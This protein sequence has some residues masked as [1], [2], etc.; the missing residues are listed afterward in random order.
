MFLSARSSRYEKNRRTGKRGEIREVNKKKHARMPRDD[1]IWT[2]KREWGSVGCVGSSTAHA[3]SQISEQRD[4]WITLVFTI[5][6]KK[7]GSKHKQRKFYLIS[8]R[9]Y[10]DSGGADFPAPDEWGEPFLPQVCTR[11]HHLSG[12]KENQ[13]RKAFKLTLKLPI[14]SSNKSLLACSLAAQLWVYTDT[15]PWLLPLL[16]LTAPSAPGLPVCLH[17]GPD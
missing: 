15:H 5:F 4:L 7:S 17:G 12:R 9:Y 1:H 10:H 3:Q 2:K 8:I 11:K 13:N 16:T 6:F 14:I